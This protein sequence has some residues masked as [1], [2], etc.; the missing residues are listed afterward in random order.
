MPEKRL[1]P[2]SDLRIEVMLRPPDSPDRF[3][4]VCVNISEHG[5]LVLTDRLQ[6]RGTVLSFESRAFDG[7]AEVIW[8]RETGEASETLVGIQFLSLD[9]EDRLALLRILSTPPVRT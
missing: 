8:T 6:P 3:R 1:A 9:Q 5:A 2:R 7:T 4:G